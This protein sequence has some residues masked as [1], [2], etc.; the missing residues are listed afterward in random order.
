MSRKMDYILM[1]D[2][3]GFAKIVRSLTVGG[4]SPVSILRSTSG[5]DDGSWK[6]IQ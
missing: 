1:A 4:I 6:G 2:K 5:L 3:G